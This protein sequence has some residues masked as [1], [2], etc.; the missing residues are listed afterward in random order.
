MEVLEKA[1]AVESPDLNDVL[2]AQEGLEPFLKCMGYA[3]LHAGAAKKALTT[4]V[5]YNGRVLMRD[6]LIRQ[7]IRDKRTPT[8]R[9]EDLI[10]PMSRTAYFRADNREQQ[11]HE[12][13]VKAAGKKAIYSLDS[14]D[15]QLQLGAYEYAYAS[16]LYAMHQAAGN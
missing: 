11:E 7:L 5:R 12:Q 8:M 2:F 1:T 15:L 3:S 16:Y 10:K 13:K 6:A 4:A 9:E 14:D